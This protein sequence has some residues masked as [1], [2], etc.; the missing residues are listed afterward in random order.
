MQPCPLP[1]GARAR[2]PGYPL[3]V[4]NVGAMPATP[5]P[6][7]AR[8]LEALDAAIVEHERARLDAEW[9]EAMGIVREVPGAGPAAET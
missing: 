2:N 9:C 1:A 4:D 3:V 7:G 8:F 6:P 5:T